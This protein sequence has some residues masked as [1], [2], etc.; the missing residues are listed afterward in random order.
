[1]EREREQLRGQ[2]QGK[3]LVL[4]EP[5]SGTNT[6][7][8]PPQDESQIQEKRQRAKRVLVMASSGILKELLTDLCENADVRT[9]DIIIKYV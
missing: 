1:M 2:E 3:T 9:L 5:D 6:E 4:T 7:H 8:T